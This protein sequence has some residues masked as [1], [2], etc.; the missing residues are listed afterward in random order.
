[1][2]FKKK[3]KISK[4]LKTPKKLKKPIDFKDTIMKLANVNLL[5]V[6]KVKNEVSFVDVFDLIKDIKQ[7]E[8]VIKNLKE[9]KERRNEK[10]PIRIVVPNRFIHTMLRR[11]LF[12]IN[13]HSPIKITKNLINV[14]PNTVLFVFSDN[15]KNDREALLKKLM[16]RKVFVFFTTTGIFG[17]YNLFIKDFNLKKL[18]FFLTLLNKILTNEKN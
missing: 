16:I 9:R 17:S 7:L 4:I 10:L 5:T 15:F 2:N 13:R 1:M 12:K 6:E 8:F 11:Y 14:R 18:F 3:A